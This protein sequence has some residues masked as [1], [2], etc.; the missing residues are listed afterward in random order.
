MAS[1]VIALL[2]AAVALFVLPAVADAGHRRKHYYPGQEYNHRGWSNEYYPYYHRHYRS[3]WEYDRH[4]YSY[5]PRRYYP[6]YNSGYWRPTYELRIRRDCCRP[7]AALP[8]YYQAWGYPKRYYAHRK[9]RR[10][11]RHW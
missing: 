2:V 11:H 4:A 8:P 9:Y 10:H 1:R 6:Y 7:Y 3:D 5:K